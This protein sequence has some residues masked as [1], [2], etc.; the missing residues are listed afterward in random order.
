MSLTGNE[1]V[2]AIGRTSA[3]ANELALEVGLESSLVGDEFLDILPL[4]ALLTGPAE[5]FSADVDVDVRD[6]PGLTS[7]A[8]LLTTALAIAVNGLRSL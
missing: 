4:D 5:F 7:L 2:R 3:C 1:G 6:T 8:N